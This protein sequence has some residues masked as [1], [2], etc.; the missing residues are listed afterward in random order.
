[1]KR[2]VEA[3]DLLRVRRELSG[4]GD[5]GET[6]RLVQRREW[7]QLGEACLDGRIDDAR[8]EEVTAVNHAMADGD[9][10]GGV[11]LSRQALQHR[12]Q[13]RRVIR[14]ARSADIVDLDPRHTLERARIERADLETR[15]AGVDGQQALHGDHTQSR[16]AG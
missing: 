6:L 11:E 15:R 14:P 2:R 9:P 12:T 7:N 10:L 16:I 13:R 5:R 4:R 3:R 1:M 8:P